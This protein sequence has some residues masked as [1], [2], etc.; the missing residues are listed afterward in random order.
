M[1]TY[2]LQLTLLRDTTFG[3][4]DGVAGLLNTEVD[5]DEYG[6]PF[7]RGR[8]LKGLL[9][10]ECA[11]ILFALKQQGQEMTRWYAAARFLFGE[12]GS[13]LQG[14][15]QLYVG[16]ACLPAELQQTL[17][18]RHAPLKAAEAAQFRT[19]V[20]NALTTI[21]R[22][23]A[24]EIDGVAKDNSLRAIRLIIRETQ[25]E[26]PLTFLSE[27]E[28]VP[29]AKGL[30]AA[31]VKSLRRA[32]TSRSRGPGLIKAELRQDGQ[33]ISHDWLTQFFKTEVR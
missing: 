10:Y 18:I 30:L 33:A 26:A 8:A 27:I 6:L 17:M 5:H 24:V 25:F 20:L 4:G 12:P 32:G 9:V 22:Q 16:N 23:T 29:L 31:C 7:L 11:D 15:A 28:V 21:R 13:N 2:S 1:S 3:R 19:E 14:Q